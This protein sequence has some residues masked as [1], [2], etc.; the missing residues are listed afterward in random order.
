[1]A[2]KKTE[3]GHGKNKC[4]KYKCKGGCGKSYG[5][6]RYL[7]SNQEQISV[8]TN[9]GHTSVLKE[10]Y[11]GLTIAPENQHVLRVK[12]DNL[13]KMNNDAKSTFDLIYPVTQVLDEVKRGPSEQDKDPGYRRQLRD[14]MEEYC[15][16]GDQGGANSIMFQFIKSLYNHRNEMPKILWEIKDLPELEKDKEAYQ[17]IQIYLKRFKPSEAA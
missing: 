6:L 2:I 5:K 11:N 13:N 7:K 17:S 3:T 9:A 12:L 4:G 10:K 14:Q 16:K 8:K 15:R 1:M